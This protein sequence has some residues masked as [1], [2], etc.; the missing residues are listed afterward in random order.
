MGATT[1]LKKRIASAS[2]VHFFGT[3]VFSLLLRIVFLTSRVQYQFSEKALPYLSGAQPAIFCFWHGRMIM[4]PFVKPRGRRMYVLISH[5]NDGALITRTMRWFGIDSVRIAR[6]RRGVTA[7]RELFAVTER[8]DNIAI[9]PDG[10]RGPFQQ[11]ADGAAYVAMKTG[12]AIIPVTFSA[13]RY[14]R[15]RSWDRFMIPKFFTRIVFIAVDPMIL[16]D[17]GDAALQTATATLETCLT[18]ITAQADGML[19]VVS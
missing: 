16:S 7:M 6:K 18:D 11:A 13:R 17:E 5:H 3:L 14:W 1:S 4:H 8:G 2:L 15:L 10:P 9:T 12:Y 19:G